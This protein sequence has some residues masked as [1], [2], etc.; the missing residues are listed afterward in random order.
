MII[1]YCIFSY[2]FMIG[3]L[4]NKNYKASETTVVFLF[5]L[6]PVIVPIL[7]GQKFGE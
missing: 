6:A 1:A 5:L 3:I 7:L 2:L 4:G